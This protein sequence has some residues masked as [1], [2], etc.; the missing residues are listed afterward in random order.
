MKVSKVNNR[1]LKPICNNRF[2]KRNDINI[3]T[4]NG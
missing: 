2:A 4:C 1:R 3:L